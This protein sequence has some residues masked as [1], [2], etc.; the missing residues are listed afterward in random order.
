MKLLHL[1]SQKSVHMAKGKK[2]IPKE[3]FSQLVSASEVLETVQQEA[4]DYRKEVAKEGEQ[5][6]EEAEAKGFETGLDRWAKQISLLEQEITSV[7]K[8][9]EKLITSV[10]LTSAKKIVGREIE[11]DSKTIADIIASSLRSV[12]Q[13]KKIK[14]YVNKNDLEAVEA[15]KDRL[16]K[17]F[18]SLESL[19]IQ[20]RSDIEPNGAVIETEMG[21][22]NAQFDVLWARLENALQ[23]LTSKDKSTS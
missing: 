23:S 8:E 5:L 3:E 17:V 1:I 20:P 13:H 19:S 2:V 10:A 11:L 4:I 6:K 14:V 7:R 16:K 18:E 21:I 9:M 22:I 15:H 12:S